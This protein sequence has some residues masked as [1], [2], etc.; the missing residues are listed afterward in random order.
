[1]SLSKAPGEEVKHMQVRPESAKLEIG[2][3]DPWVATLVVA[4]KASGI[5]VLGHWLPGLP[6]V[7]LSF[8]DLRNKRI[9]QGPPVRAHGGER[10]QH[11]NKQLTPARRLES[12]P[13]G[14][15]GSAE[16]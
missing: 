9:L 8:S 14:N 10:L 7:Q 16:G 6:L 4:S 15:R 13:F 1:M 2:H 5:K 11:T 3:S 12:A